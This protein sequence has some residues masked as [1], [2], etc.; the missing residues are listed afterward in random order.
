MLTVGVTELITALK[1]EGEIVGVEAAWSGVP[2][3]LMMLGP[4]SF[5]AWIFA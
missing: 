2:T 5:T 3:L 4:L 1:F